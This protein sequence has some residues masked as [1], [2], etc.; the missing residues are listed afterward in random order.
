MVYQVCHMMKPFLHHQCCKTSFL[1]V[2]YCF[3]LCLQCSKFLLRKKLVVG[4]FVSSSHSKT[5]KMR[6]FYYVDCLNS[7]LNIISIQALILQSL[8]TTHTYDG[9][10]EWFY[11][12][13]H[14]S[15]LVA[16]VVTSFQLAAGYST[17]KRDVLIF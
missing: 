11:K 12:G 6:L 5:Y 2:F 13:S 10:G 15:E 9:E 14:I 7:S 16:G 3:S 8:E 4:M 1:S 17:V